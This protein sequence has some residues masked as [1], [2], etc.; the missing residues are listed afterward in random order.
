[1]SMRGVFTKIVKLV[2]VYKKECVLTLKSDRP[3]KT[4]YKT[5]K[6][7]IIGTSKK[8]TIKN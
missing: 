8:G 1:M 5:H 7:P 4:M 6:W 3:S 2:C